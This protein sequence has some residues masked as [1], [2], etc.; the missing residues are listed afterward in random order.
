LCYHCE[1]YYYYY[2]YDGWL[3]VVYKAAL[4]VKL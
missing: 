4:A 2:D 3:L 1:N